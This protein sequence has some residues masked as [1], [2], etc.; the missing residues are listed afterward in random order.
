LHRVA[1]AI[2]DS[3]RARDLLG[4]KPE[5]SELEMQIA[6]AWNWMKRQNEA[7]ERLNIESGIGMKHR[8]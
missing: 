2:G 1:E 4:W 3:S 8:A 7:N 6:D 5:R